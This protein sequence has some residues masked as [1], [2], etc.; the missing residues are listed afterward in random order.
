MT[1]DAVWATRRDPARFLAPLSTGPIS[2]GCLA[3]DVQHALF[4]ATR[5]RAVASSDAKFS[6]ATLLYDGRSA[7]LSSSSRAI[8]A[9]TI[10]ATTITVSTT[11]SFAAANSTTSVTTTS[12]A[13][14]FTTAITTTDLA[15]AT[16]ATATA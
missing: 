5:E 6:S 8:T 15:T 16:T 1:R 2:F 3:R 9:S 13:T 12:I 4:R 14:A 11:A 7:A 10:A